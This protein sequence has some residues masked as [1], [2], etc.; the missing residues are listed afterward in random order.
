M[1]PERTAIVERALP[2]IEAAHKGGFATVLAVEDATGLAE[3]MVLGRV[4]RPV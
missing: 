2:G 1:P 4:P 3:V